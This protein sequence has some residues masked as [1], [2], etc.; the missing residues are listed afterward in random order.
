MLYPVHLQVIARMI[1]ILAHTGS[2]IQEIGS[3]IRLSFIR[4]AFTKPS[5]ANRLLNTIE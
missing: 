1:R 3:A 4:I 5:V 2:V